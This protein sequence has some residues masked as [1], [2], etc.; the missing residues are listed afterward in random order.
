MSKQRKKRQY[1]RREINIGDK[2]KHWT[3]ID[4]PKINNHGSYIYNAECD[5]KQTTRWFQANALTKV[6]GNTQCQKC[7]AKDRGLVQSAPKRVGELNQTRFAHLQRSA[8]K[9][10]YSF[11]LTIK[12]LWDLFQKQNQICAITGEYIQS[13]KKAS[14]DRIDSSIGYIEG[15][16]QWTTIQA[17]KCKHILSMSELLEFCHKVINHA[18]QQPS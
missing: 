10:G 16:V 13:I 18:N 11:N 3:V 7:A 12:I 5:C 14:L 2:F 8:I 15:N 9:R 6:D 17:N 1:L 4:G